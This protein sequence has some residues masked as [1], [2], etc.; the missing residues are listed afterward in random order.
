MVCSFSNT[1]TPSHPDGMSSLFLDQFTT[2][3]EMLGEGL[4]MCNFIGLLQTLFLL[5]IELAVT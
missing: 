2:T 5:P 3:L 4:Q 1:L